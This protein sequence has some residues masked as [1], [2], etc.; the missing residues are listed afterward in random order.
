MLI[1]DGG[2][3]LRITLSSGVKSILKKVKLDE[4]AHKN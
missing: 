3:A 2:T 4:Y 1:Q